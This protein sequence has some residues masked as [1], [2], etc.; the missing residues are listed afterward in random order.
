METRDGKLIKALSY[1]DHA[2]VVFKRDAKTDKKAA[3]KWTV[4][5]VLAVAKL[6]IQDTACA[7]FTEGQQKHGAVVPA[8]SG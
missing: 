7:V 8:E 4:H 6:K 3:C 1:P 5:E 2:W